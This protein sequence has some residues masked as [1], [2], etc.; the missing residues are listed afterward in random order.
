MKEETCP[1]CDVDFIPEDHNDLDEGWFCD[2]CLS[3]DDVP[4]N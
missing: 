2:A 4:D 1:S 3:V